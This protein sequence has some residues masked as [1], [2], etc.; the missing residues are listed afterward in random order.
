MSSSRAVHAVGVAGAAYAA[1]AAGAASVTPRCRPAVIVGPSGVG[2]STLLKRLQAE[3]GEDFGFSVSHTT[4]KPRAGE[5]DGVDYHFAN[6]DAVR[7]EIKRGSFVEYAEVHGNIYG[8]SKRAVNDVL[9]ANRVCLLDID[10]QGSRICRDVGLEVG[11]HIFIAPPSLDTLRTRLE[12]RGTET[13]ESL[14]KRL[15]NAKGE[16]DGATTLSWDAWIVN[17]D[18][19]VAYGRFRETLMP[20]VEECRAAR[21]AAAERS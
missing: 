9:D 19:D 12:G 16:I 3:F 2:K 14:A 11:R 6:I 1:S 7:A 17:D 13:P 8:T 21:A 10:I 18:V 5:K 4:R 20:L 15:G